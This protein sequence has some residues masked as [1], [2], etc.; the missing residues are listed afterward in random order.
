MARNARHSPASDTMLKSRRQLWMTCAGAAAGLLVWAYDFDFF[1]NA[2]GPAAPI[3]QAIL[4][5]C[6]LQG[7]QFPVPVLC[8]LLVLV[9]SG[10]ALGFAAGLCLQAFE[11]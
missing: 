1:L 3:S 2:A 11:P 4:R 5:V 7:A 10:S 9:I 6:H 8:P